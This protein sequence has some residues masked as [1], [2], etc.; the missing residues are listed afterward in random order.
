M[1]GKFVWL[2][3]SLSLVDCCTNS[4]LIS[5]KEHNN[6]EDI[7][8]NTD[9]Y[10]PDPDGYFDDR[11]H[12]KVKT[13]SDYIMSCHRFITFVDTKA[14]Y[15]YKGGVYVEGGETTII[16]Q[17]Q[18][19]LGNAT[20]TKH[21]KEIIHYVQYATLVNRADM[22]KCITHINL[23]NGIYNLITDELEPHTPD[24]VFITQIPVAYDSDAECLN[25]DKFLHEITDSSRPEDV[26]TIYEV[27]GYCM[28]PDTRIQ[29]SLMLVGDG[30]NG[31]SKLLEAIG[32]FIGIENSSSES[33][34]A[35]TDDPYSTA[36]LYG[37]LVNIFPDLASR[38]IYE[39]SMFK[40]LTG[41]DGLVRGAKKYGQPFRFKNT[42][43]L[44][45]SANTLPATPAGDYAYMRRWIILMF[46]NTFVGADVDVNL[47][48]KL[49]NSQEQSG[50]LNV[51]LP[52]LKQIMLQGDFT[53]SP[54]TNATETV[55]RLNSD[56]IAVFMETMVVPSD[57]ACVRKVM[58][59]Y[60][61]EW[62][63]THNI[64]PKHTKVFSKRLL[65]L[66]YTAYRESSGDRNY[67]WDECMITK[68]L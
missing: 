47:T 28:I 68:F 44:I 36:E 32:S 23:L 4:E 46:P 6:T 54:L 17:V 35:L 29:R 18:D 1:L 9:F 27:I 30:A 42:A 52:L 51:I 24:K 55:Y 48:A 25:F 45:F 8:H 61:E 19:L 7:L 58:Y 14:V 67:V 34:H 41:D 22:N 53:H 26:Q 20:R 64:I 33:L 49:C 39:N 16:K 66:G 59:E 5:M 57:G 56:P 31:K 40:S 3:H 62:S 65:K 37:K 11:K 38:A 2:P 13:I 60:Y 21:E 12:L 43:R 15:E 50:I 10:P 63:K